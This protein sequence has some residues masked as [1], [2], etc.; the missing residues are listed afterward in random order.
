MKADAL[1]AIAEWDRANITTRSA[2]LEKAR[3]IDSTTLGSD[4]F[5]GTFRVDERQNAVFPYRTQEGLVGIERRNRPPAEGQKSFKLYTAGGV[6]GI[7]T[8]NTTPTDTRL[9]VVES[10]IDAM[11]HWQMLPPQL[12]AVTRYAAIRQGF[13]E[14]D[15]GALIDAMPSGSAIIA[16]CDADRAGDDYNALIRRL[17]PDDR[18]SVVEVPPVGK[19]WNDALRL[20]RREEEVAVFTLNSRPRP[21][22]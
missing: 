15:L 20:Q 19:D 1:R 14:A 13:K 3:G 8:P 5:R 17:T 10:P 6:P 11:S 18:I 2:F 22:R 4:R 7:W 9:V 21:R 12:Q 16:A